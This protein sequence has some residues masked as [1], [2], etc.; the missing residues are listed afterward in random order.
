MDT[1]IAD[2]VVELRSQYPL[3]KAIEIA[4]EIGISR[5]RVRQILTVRGLPTTV[6]LPPKLCPACGHILP[7]ENKGELCQQ[8]LRNV[9]VT[10]VCFRCRREYQCT[11]LESRRRRTGYCRDCRNVVR[12]RQVRFCLYH[13][14]W[15]HQKK[16]HKYR[17]IFCQSIFDSVTEFSKH[18]VETGE[19]SDPDF[20]KWV[21][22]YHSTHSY[23]QTLDYFHISQET[24][25]AIRH[26][27][28]TTKHH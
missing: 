23:W 28:E 20:R 10:H 21:M 9:Q 8:C 17:C 5:E 7:G 6:A 19:L 13:R 25:K 26:G 1:G 24:Y 11:L 14:K 27:K 15:K 3:M 2:K 16:S 12:R 18:R 22:A 4:R